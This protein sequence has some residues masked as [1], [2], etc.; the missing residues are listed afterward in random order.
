MTV[1]RLTHKNRACDFVLNIDTQDRLRI[2]QLTDMQIIDLGCTRN[3]V[4]DRQIKNAYFK[5]G[6][7]SMDE[8]CFVYV[9]ELIDK[10]S[11]HLILMTGDNVYGE[12]DDSGRMLRLLCERMEEYGVYWAPIFGNH[13]NESRLG[14]RKQIEIMSGY[15]HCLFFDNGVTGHSNYN[16]CVKQNGEDVLGIYMLDSNGCKTVGNPWAPEEGITEDNIDYDLIEHKQGIYDDQIEFVAERADRIAIASGKRIP[17][18]ACFHIPIRIF[19]KAF[20]EK[21][22]YVKGMDF[23]ANKDSDFGRIVEHG[24]HVGMDEDLRFHTMAK[25]IGIK[26]YLVGH[27]HNNNACIKYDGVWLNYGVKTG[28]CTYYKNDSVGGT[29]LTLNPDGELEFSHVLCKNR[30]LNN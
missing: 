21:Y 26:A 8:R 1:E 7:P 11:P 15:P 10:T 27:E 19:D 4:R 17:S 25:K 30:L 16:I 3:P 23:V 22:G 29:L 28:V 13:D 5:E 20:E 14:V 24:N 6:V 12:F 18:I 9:K 2:L